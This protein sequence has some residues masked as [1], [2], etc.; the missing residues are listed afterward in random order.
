MRGEAGGFKEVAFRPG[1]Q[2][3][4]NSFSLE[5]AKK[6]PGCKKTK[7]LTAFGELKD[8]HNG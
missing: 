7:E 5:K 3:I 4:N 1:F 2:R 6:V 8:M